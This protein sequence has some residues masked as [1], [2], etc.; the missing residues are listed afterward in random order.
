MPDLAAP[1]LLRADHDLAGFACGKPPLD[2]FLKDHALDKQNAMLSRTYVATAGGTRVVAYHT[3][4]HVGVSQA[5]AP[6]RLGR[7]MPSAIPAILLA[8]LAVD[9]GFH[10]QGLGRSLFAD[11]LSRAWAVMRDGPAPVRLFVVDAK[12]DEARAFY[13]RMRMVP[14]P[15]DPLRLFLGYKDLRTVFETP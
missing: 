9:Q 13:E 1:E 4:A 2:A 6:K 15:S 7:G 12:D 3:L 10:G 11:A 5:E 8:R 14:S